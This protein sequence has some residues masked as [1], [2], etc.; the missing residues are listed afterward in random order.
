MKSSYMTPEIVLEP[1]TQND[2]F[3]YSYQVTGDGDSI[4]FS[5]LILR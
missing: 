3:C 2:I 4:S 5:D 1:I